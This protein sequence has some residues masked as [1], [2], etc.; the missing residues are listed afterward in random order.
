MELI[1]LKIFQPSA[2][3]RKQETVSKYR[4]SYKLPP[5]STVIG[6]IH[7]MCG[8]K[9]YVDMDI[10]I[11]GRY[12]NVYND[13]ATVYFYNQK[14]QYDDTRHNI[15]YFHPEHDKDQGAIKSIMTYETIFMLNLVVH[16]HVKDET[17]KDL[18]LKGLQNPAKTP[19]LGRAEDLALIEEVSLVEVKD[20]EDEY[21]MDKEENKYD[22]YVPFY[23]NENDDVS[24]RLKLNK[25]YV[26]EKG[27]RIW[28][29]IIVTNY[30]P[31]KSLTIANM[32]DEDELPVFLA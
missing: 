1:R 16:I 32:I 5:Y 8:L 6:F 21:Y 19:V 14:G 20:E 10:S 31:A 22:A 18:I 27:S 12:E 15:K 2:H 28:E 24:T 29:E 13:L 30:I 9:E 3:F 17:K 11:Q 7:N 25:K 23:L 26:I 4:S